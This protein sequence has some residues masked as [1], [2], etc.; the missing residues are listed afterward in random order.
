MGERDIEGGHDDLWV[1]NEHI[2]NRMDAPLVL[3]Q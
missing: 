3:E 2:T 1:V